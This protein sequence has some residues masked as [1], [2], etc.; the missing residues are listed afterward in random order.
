MSCRPPSISKVAP[1]TAVL[2]MRCAA[3]AALPAGPTTR[4]IGS[5]ARRSS[6]RASIWSPGLA[7]ESGVSPNFSDSNGSSPSWRRRG[8]VCVAGNADP[9]GIDQHGIGEDQSVQAAVLT[10]GDS[11]PAFVSPELGEREPTR[12]F[13]S[14]LILLREGHAARDG[15]R[16]TKYDG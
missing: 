14:V 2:V 10:D 7:A 3:G 12:Y 6:R 5:V 15:E 16:Q 9:V 8:K 4:Q 1:V 13:Q 11:L